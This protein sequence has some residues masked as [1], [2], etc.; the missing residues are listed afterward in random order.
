MRF[1]YWTVQFRPS[2]FSLTV[3]GLGV[4]AQ[5]PRTGHSGYRKHTAQGLGVPKLQAQD[6]ALEMAGVLFGSVDSVRADSAT[7]EISDGLDIASY[8]NRSVELWNNSL[9]VD[10]P[11]SV[12]HDSLNEALELLHRAFVEPQK[13]APRKR[14]LTVVRESLINAYRAKD[15]LEEKLSID[16]VL[17]TSDRDKK[18]DFAVLEGK[19]IYEISSAFNFQV[20]DNS[21]LLNAA[22]S[23]AYRISELRKEGGLLKIPENEGIRVSSQV[24]VVAVFYPP[25]TR[26]QN[27]VFS[28]CEL[29]WKRLGVETV[30]FERIP[31][32]ADELASRVPA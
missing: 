9:I 14:R 1:D 12:E 23:W 20:E 28:M 32:H 6:L 25:R 21:G 4:I 17:E 7:L 10:G 29:T 18:L 26:E 11:F 22:D 19:E 24:P 16:P 27:E 2:P 5:D 30:P 15:T 31:S 3:Y 8:L 13:R